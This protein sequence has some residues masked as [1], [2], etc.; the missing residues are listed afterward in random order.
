MA[1]EIIEESNDIVVEIIREISA[2][3]VETITET[4][5][6]QGDPGLSAYQVAVANGFVG[7]EAAWLASLV[8]PSGSGGGGATNTFIQ[9]TDPISELTPGFGAY[10]WYVTDVD[11]A[12][13]DIRKGVA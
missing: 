9:L 2:S 13:L 11:G 6:T 12:V 4:L 3:P 1:E 8:G 10:I 5:G 7:N